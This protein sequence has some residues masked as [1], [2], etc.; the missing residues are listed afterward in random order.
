MIER[1]MSGKRRKPVDHDEAADRKAADEAS[2]A[3]HGDPGVADA[4]PPTAE[5]EDGIGAAEAAEVP[6]T[7]DRLTAERDELNDRY[8]RL[9]A[10]FDNFRKRVARERAELRHRSQAELARKLLEALDDL[11]RV[12]ALEATTTTVHDVIS[13]VHL[14]EQKLMQELE[15]AGLQ[16]VGAEGE[17]FDPNDHEAVAT[18]PA[19]G[20]EEAGTVGSVLQPGYRFGEV[21]LRPAR[22]VVW[23][24][25]EPPAE[26]STAGV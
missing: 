11:G 16:R 23:V 25:G 26:A 9:A 12:V 2:P 20:D 5:V 3:M 14:V 1:G 21:L 15:H 7:V 18:Q 24:E 22:V 10:E 17:L 6:E 19:A 4:V 13:G 8:L